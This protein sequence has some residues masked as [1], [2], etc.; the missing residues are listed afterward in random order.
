MKKEPEQAAYYQ[1]LYDKGKR[2]FFNKY[3]Q[4][5]RSQ[6]LKAPHI[7]R[8]GTPRAWDGAWFDPD[9]YD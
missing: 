1:A 8:Y 2:E 5:T 6:I 9:Y 7:R 4:R 3:S